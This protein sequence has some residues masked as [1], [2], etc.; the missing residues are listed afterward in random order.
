MFTLG[1]LQRYTQ[2][3]TALLSAAAAAVAAVAA[4]AAAAFIVCVYF[5]SLL[6]L[7]ILGEDMFKEI[8][9]LLSFLSPLPKPLC[10]LTPQTLNP[11]P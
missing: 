9:S 1:A 6:W 11:K 7:Y 3:R 5:V 2:L 8:E 10:Q 4:V